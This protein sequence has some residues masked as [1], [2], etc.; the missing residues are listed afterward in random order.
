MFT[1]KTIAQGAA[2]P[3]A[4]VDPAFGRTGGHYL[5]DAREAYT[6]PDHAVMADHPHGVKQWALDPD[7]ATRLWAVSSRLI[8]HGDGTETARN[9][10]L[11]S[12]ETG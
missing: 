2:T 3:V 4:A 1:Y 11:Q 6:V 9:S 8:R 5:D 7:L 10:Q 12:E